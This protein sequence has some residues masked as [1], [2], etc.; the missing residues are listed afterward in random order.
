MEIPED[1][2]NRQLRPN[3]NLLIDLSGNKHGHVIWCMSTGNIYD[4]NEKVLCAGYPR[5]NPEVPT[6][7]SGIPAPMKGFGSKAYPMVFN[8]SQMFDY[9]A[10]KQSRYRNITIVMPETISLADPFFRKSPLFRLLE[11]FLADIDS[12]KA[13]F[14]NMDRSAKTIVE[15]ARQFAGGEMSKT[16][17]ALLELIMKHAQNVSALATKSQE[18]KKKEEEKNKLRQQQ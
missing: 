3:S 11:P 16:Q 15:L 1:M 9:P 10:G 7:L 6:F 8:K 4:D 13:H 18:D 17:F 5:D 12:Y 2:L 14:E